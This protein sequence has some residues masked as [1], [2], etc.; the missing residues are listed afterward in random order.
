MNLIQGKSSSV[1]VSSIE[2]ARIQHSVEFISQKIWIPFNENMLTFHVRFKWMFAFS[3]INF[4]LVICNRHLFGFS[5]L[6]DFE[7]WEMT[8][9]QILVRIVQVYLSVTPSMLFLCSECLSGKG[10]EVTF[11]HIPNTAKVRALKSRRNAVEA[12][13]LQR[14]IHGNSAERQERCSTC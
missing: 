9:L 1:R 10:D 3:F 6:Q 14:G 7:R 11:P 2:S 4:S 13:V 8:N 5:A 12:G